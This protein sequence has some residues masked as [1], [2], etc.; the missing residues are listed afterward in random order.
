MIQ[1]P[2]QLL[3]ISVLALPRRSQELVH[4]HVQEGQQALP[5]QLLRKK[6]L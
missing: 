1:S 4:C 5:Y 3:V 6:K 2:L